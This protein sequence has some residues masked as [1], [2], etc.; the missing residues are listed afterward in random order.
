[1]S[2]FANNAA[3]CGSLLIHG[4]LGIKLYFMGEGRNVVSPLIHGSLGIKLLLIVTML[5]LYSFNYTVQSE[6]IKT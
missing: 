3:S 5:Q 2:R 1:M 6:H 4:S